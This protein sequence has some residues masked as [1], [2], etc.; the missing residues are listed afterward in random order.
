M[1]A[2]LDARAAGTDDEPP[3]DRRE[4]DDGRV[5]DWLREGV[6]D[7]LGGARRATASAFGGLRRLRP[8][9]PA[10]VSRRAVV[11]RARARGWAPGLLEAGLQTVRAA[12]AC[13]VA[14]ALATQLP[15][16]G[17]EPVFAPLAAL[18]GVQAAG[19]AAVRE[20][21]P[22]TLALL[23]GAGLAVGTGVLVGL[24]VV[25]AAVVGGLSVLAARLLRLPAVAGAQVPFTALLLLALSGG[26]VRAAELRVLDGLLGLA[27][28]AVVAVLVVPPVQLRP[29][30]RRVAQVARDAAALLDDLAGGVPADVG[31]ALA[32]S[33]RRLVRARDL[34]LEA[35]SV[36]ALVAGG[37]E[38]VRWTPYAMG[39]RE[40]LARLD[41]A[42][43]VLE[44]VTV[45]VR[46][47]ARTLADATARRVQAGRDPVPECPDAAY[48][49][50]GHVAGALRCTAELVQDDSSLRS[51]DVRRVAAALDRVAADLATA[52]QQARELTA[53]SGQ[54]QL[55]TGALL[56]DLRRLIADLD[57]VRGAMRQSVRDHPGPPPPSPV[58][59]GPAG[60]GRDGNGAT[61][62][63][64]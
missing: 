27:V 48:T 44:R 32:A 14:F 56:E 4:D 18:L 46:G 61:R 7:L 17:G 50:L 11:E 30:Q 15:E 54:P 41:E 9:V 24:T 53:A 16:G 2:G 19:A 22:R 35:E 3:D 58:R 55:L 51:P 36:R 42:A 49:A 23:A 59:P 57:P 10:R 26:D 34:D 60:Q 8:P 5:P 64:A 28:G 63:D 52:E 12:L 21:L 39:A 40:R 1:T 13:G 37:A 45:Q 29:A 47:V 43:A 62:P 25:S 20:A 38:A 6:V 33:R 31:E